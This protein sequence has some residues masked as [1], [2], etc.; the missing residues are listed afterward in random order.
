[1][2]AAAF[3]HLDTPPALMAPETVKRKR[4]NR[5]GRNAALFVGAVILMDD[6]TA[7]QIV[8]LH[9]EPLCVPVSAQEPPR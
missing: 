4:R 3:L 2:L 5:S 7:C 1:M 8:A 6:G 9:P